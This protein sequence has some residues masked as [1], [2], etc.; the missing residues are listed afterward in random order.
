MAYTINI[1]L[2]TDIPAQSQPLM[3]DNCNEIAAALAIDHGAFNTVE[4][5]EHAKVSFVNGIPGAWPA[6]V[7]N[8]LYATAD[9]IFTHSA[10]GDFNI[11]A[12]IATAYATADFAGPVYATRLASGAIIKYGRVQK[13]NADGLKDLIF[14]VAANIPVFTVVHSVLLTG[15]RLGALGTPK[16]A[17]YET[18]TNLILKMNLWEFT[19]G[20]NATGYINFYVIGQ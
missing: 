19:T 8:G 18:C 1:P 5:G 4:Q 12:N 13:L 7:T 11:T 14:P 16:Y 17:Y 2:A 15:Y 6:G 3:L 20:A 10:A 9:G